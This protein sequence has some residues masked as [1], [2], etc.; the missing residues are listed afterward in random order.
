MQ[1]NSNETAW[2]PVDQPEYLVVYPVLWEPLNR[3]KF[4]RC[5][6]EM[7]KRLLAEARPGEIKEGN[8][9]FE[10]RPEAYDLWYQP[11]PLDHPKFPVEFLRNPVD[12][13]RNQEWQQG[14]VEAL[15]QPAMPL[16]EALAAA[17]SLSLETYL[18]HLI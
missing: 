3:E 13:S 14:V 16:Q 7:F 1:L 2:A 12:G 6:V 5:Q 4:L 15:L 9:L 10:C 11:D 17:E 8:Y 18:S